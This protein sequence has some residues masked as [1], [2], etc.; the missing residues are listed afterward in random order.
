M[1]QRRQLPNC[2]EVALGAFLHDIG[3]FISA[4][5]APSPK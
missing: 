4:P 5:S 3:K 1:N 2:D